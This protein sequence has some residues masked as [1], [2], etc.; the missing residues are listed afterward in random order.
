MRLRIPLTG[1]A[2]AFACEP[3]KFGVRV[4][5][6]NSQDSFGEGVAAGRA[7]GTRLRGG[8]VRAA[9][10]DGP[11]VVTTGRKYGGAKQA[12][13][14]GEYFDT[15]ER[16]QISSCGEMGV[17]L[18]RLLDPVETAPPAAA[19]IDALAFSVVPVLDRTVISRDTAVNLCLFSTDR[20]CKMLAGEI[21]VVRTN[22]IRRGQRVVRQVV[23]LCNLPH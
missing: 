10:M 9:A 5:N 6:S 1:F 15:G 23:V 20:T 12:A 13:D 14:C 19:L 21:A 4:F 3:N 2:A 7:V 17:R 18:T 16:V 8:T 11:R 22:R